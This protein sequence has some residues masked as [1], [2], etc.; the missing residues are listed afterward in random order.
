MLSLLKTGELKKEQVPWDSPARKL[1][2]KEINLLLSAYFHNERLYIEYRKKYSIEES[3]LKA[4]AW[5]M[6]YLEKRINTSKL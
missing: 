1:T 5:A 4:K 3:E 6:E 2:E